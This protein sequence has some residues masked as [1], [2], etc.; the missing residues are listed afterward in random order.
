MND[1]QADAAIPHTDT[2]CVGAGA[3]QHRRAQTMSMRVMH[4]PKDRNAFA[5]MPRHMSARISDAPDAAFA[6]YPVR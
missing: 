5:A 2:W 6:A 3:H 1:G 4:P